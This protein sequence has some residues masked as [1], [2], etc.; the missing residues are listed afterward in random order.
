MASVEKRIRNGQTR[1]VARY[2]DPEGRQCA[3]SFARKVDADRFLAKTEGDKLR[4]LYV[5]P[6][7]ASRTFC[8]I[9]EQHWTAYSHTL[10]EDT[11]RVRKRSVLDRHILPTL[12][13]KPIGGIRPSTVAGAMAT[14]SITLAPGTVGQVLRQVR[15]IR[16]TAV[17]DGVIPT[18]P[19]KAIKPPTAPRRRDV[20]LTDEDVRRAI[21][22]APEQYRNLVIV[23]AGLGLRISEACGLRAS[24]VDFLGRVVH[25]RQ[26]RR[27]GG[28]MGKLKTGFSARDTPAVDQVLHA[29]SVQIRRWPRR[30]GLISSSNDRPLTKSVAGHVFDHV[31]ETINGGPITSATDQ[32]I[33][34]YL[35]RGKK[36]ATQTAAEMARRAAIAKSQERV[37]ISPHSLRHYF[38]A[39]LISGATSVV[40][41]SEWLGHSSPEITWRVYS[42]LMPSDQEV[43]RAALTKMLGAVLSGVYQVCNSTQPEAL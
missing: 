35:W 13:G 31:E 37:T 21:E 32:G 2:R 22:A 39:S 18:K 8:D 23:L 1:C 24:D 36:Y 12:G 11:T 17:L 41:V 15:Q 29:L 7:E 40:A 27:P 6:R 3:R 10:S 28:T 14:W 5:D 9:A 34:S 25:V 43:G 4:G 16:A 20:H 42:Y 33:S 38:G 26:Q 30:D 19:A